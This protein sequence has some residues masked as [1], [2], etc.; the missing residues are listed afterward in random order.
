VLKKIHGKT[1]YESLQN[2]STELKVNASSVPSTLGGGQNGHSGL[3]LSNDQ[4]ITMAHAIPWV[5]PGNPGTFDGP[6]IKAAAKESGK[7]SNKNL[8]S[9]K[10]PTRHLSRNLLVD[11]I[12]PIYLRAMLNRATGQYSTNIRALVLHLFATYGKITPQQV[13]AKEMELY[14]MHYNI[15]Q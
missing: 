10:I 8:N 13:K 9:V 1:T 12:N 2:V 5:T 11:L 4:Y 6:Q 14:N 7:N 3:L 15:S